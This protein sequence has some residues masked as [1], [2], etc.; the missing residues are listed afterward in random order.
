MSGPLLDFS[1]SASGGGGGGSV[2][3]SGTANTLTKWTATGSTV[4]NSSITDNGTTVTFTGA[5]I[6]ST[7]VGGLDWAITNKLNFGGNLLVVDKTNLRVGV[8][9]AFPTQ[10]F[11]VAGQTQIGSGLTGRGANTQ[12]LVSTGGIGT[13]ANETG[14][15][16]I[17]G[18]TI[19]LA[20]TSTT[21]A[22]VYGHGWTY[23]SG[24]TAAGFS[25]GVIGEGHVSNTADVDSSIGVRGYSQ[26]T[27]AG[28]WNIGLYGN[29]SGSSTG[30]YALYMAAGDIRSAAAQTWTL[31][32]STSALNIASNL[33]NLDTTNNR[34]G[35]GTA[36]PGTQ[37]HISRAGGTSNA[38]YI[39]LQNTT[40]A[41]GSAVGINFW[42]N[43][44]ATTVGRIEG[45][46]TAGGSY[47][48]AFSNWNGSA[49]AEGMRLTGSGNVGIGTASP[50]AKLHIV[51]P[52]GS[53]YPFA[54]AG[55][56]KGLRIQTT[57]SQVQ[58]DGVDST[59]VGSYQPL[60]LNG[61]TVTLAT[62]GTARVTTDASGNVGIGTTSPG[63]KLDVQGTGSFTG[64]FSFNSGYGSSTVA[65]GTRAWVNFNGATGAIRASGNV[66]SVTRSATGTYVV[67]FASA[68]PDVN[69]A[70]SAFAQWSGGPYVIGYTTGAYLAGSVGVT[71]GTTAGVAADVSILSIIITR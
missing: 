1:L 58:I 67:N 50:S 3:G 39:R 42:Q 36:S 12:L 26:D 8:G 14:N 56:T 9:S 31:A 57:A 51:T 25:A 49:L 52:D 62:G 59:L 48:T 54:L 18:E 7:S 13:P 35:I 34:V 29:A 69:Y 47:D 27:H 11:H 30:N 41:S 66:S 33:F 28:G 38:E 16:G 63:Y 70:V 65:Y 71:S 40:A 17:F 10:F 60:F 64:N 68:M 4:G 20:G 32:S 6:A 19:A 61:S 43:N 53:P 37:L 5:N 45:T 21:S 2:S 24:A 55:T 22:G 15:I 44:A 23:G 46:V